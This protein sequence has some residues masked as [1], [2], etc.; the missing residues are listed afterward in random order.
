MSAFFA[1]ASSTV[2]TGSSGVTSIRTARTAASTRSGSSCASSSTGS[3]AWRIS[4]AASSGWSSSIS[5]T[6]FSPGMSRW[7]A[8]TTPDQSKAGSSSIDRMMPRATIERTVRP[9]S[10]PGTRRSST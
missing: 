5:A 1:S 8:T 10:M 3:S 9:W 4:V 2:S 6:T 7:S